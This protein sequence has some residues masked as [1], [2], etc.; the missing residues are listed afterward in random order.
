M[1][2][3]VDNGRGDIDKQ[4]RRILVLQ[5]RH[6]G[7]LR[8]VQLD[9]NQLEP[10]AVG[11][12]D[13]FRRIN[14]EYSGEMSVVLVFHVKSDRVRNEDE[15]EGRDRERDQGDEREGLEHRRDARELRNNAQRR[16]LVE[17]KASHENREVRAGAG[18]V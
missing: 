15:R 2:R 11:E 3:R 13:G 1:A 4:L 16:A 8:V 6:Y 12:S 9:E 14:E 17:I 7:R 5:D 10:L 18:P